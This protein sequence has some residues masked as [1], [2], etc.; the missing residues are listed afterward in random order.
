MIKDYLHGNIEQEAETDTYQS[1]RNIYH[2]RQRSSSRY[3]LLGALVTGILMLLLPWTQN[4]RAKGNVTGVRQEQ[5][6]QEINSVLPGRVVKWYV[7]EGDLVKKGDTLLQLD[8]VKAEYLDRQLME[9]TLEQIN[10]KQESA[11][12]YKRK[13]GTTV[14]QLNALEQ[15]KQLKLQSMDNKMEQQQLKIKTD[16]ADIQALTNELNVYKRQ[17]E[18]AGIM[19]DSGVLSLADFE[20]RKVNY[21]NSIAKITSANNKL[22]QDRQELLNLRIEQ[23][24]VRQ[25]YTD[26]IAKADGDKYTS[27][28][29]AANTAAEVSKLQ[30]QYANYDARNKLYFVTAPQDGQITSARKAGIG[31]LLKEGEM[32]VEM[33][34]DKIQYAVELFIEPM[35]LPLVAIGQKVRF[36]FDGFPA[37]VF[38]GWPANSF[39]TFGGKVTAVENAAGPNGKFRVLV[40]ED[41]AD[42]PWPKRLRVGGGASGIALLSDVRIYYEL[43]RN[44]NGFPP[45]YYKLTNNTG[46]NKK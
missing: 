14:T 40:T 7:K 39:G 31:E 44:V 2:I 19:L 15:A 46:E 38:S 26:K 27:L 12:G 41:P 33:V 25:D 4:I 24:G 16:E 30:N 36:I 18:G 13:A 22:Q 17:L 21:Q 42:R 23:N 8:E 6:P 9:R 3:W 11:E 34:P 29:S 10:A 1:F 28:S 43:W 45:D 20:K 32:L 5:R 37:I 35:D